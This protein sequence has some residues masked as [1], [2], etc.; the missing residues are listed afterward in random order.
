MGFSFDL[1][2]LQETMETARLQTSPFSCNYAV[3]RVNPQPLVP[4]EPV[5][6]ATKTLILSTVLLNYTKL[7]IQVHFLPSNIP[8]MSPKRQNNYF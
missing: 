4:Q 2:W 7:L 1:T 3:C 5:A 6:V 8:Q